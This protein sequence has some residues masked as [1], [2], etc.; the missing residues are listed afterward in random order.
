MK[1]KNQSKGFTLVET[2]VAITILI[3]SIAGPLTIAMNGLSSAILARDQITASYLAQEAV[4]YIRNKRDENAL[5]GSGWMTNI[6][7]CVSQECTVDVQ[8][9]GNPQVCGGGGCDPLKYNET[10]G[11][12][13]YSSGDIS[14]FVRSVS[15]TNIDTDEVQI[16]VTMNW[17]TGVLSR[18]FVIKENI[19][20]WQ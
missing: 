11:F 5:Q 20:N 16:V 19:F 15:L 2:L 8:S 17:V 18:S 7:Q 14:R 4:E 12:Y 9:G 6:S 3:V 10:T 1:I 13:N